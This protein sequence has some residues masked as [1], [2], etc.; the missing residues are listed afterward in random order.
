MPCHAFLL[1]RLADLA[2]GIQLRRQGLEVADAGGLEDCHGGVQAGQLSVHEL[3]ALHLGDGFGGE[4]V[5]VL[6]FV[7][8]IQN[9]HVCT[10]EMKL[11]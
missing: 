9:S 4:F 7:V 5:D 1:Q 3:Q 2:D 11:K 8:D 10:Q 6:A